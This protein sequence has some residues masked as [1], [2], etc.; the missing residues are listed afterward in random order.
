MLV[1]R[2]LHQ[3]GLRLKVIRI[4]ERDGNVGPSRCDP[5][6]HTGRGKM[7]LFGDM[8]SSESLEVLQV[9]REAQELGQLEKKVSLGL[10]LSSWR[11][12]REE[13]ESV[14]AERQKAQNSFS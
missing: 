3:P 6:W 8:A 7:E 5:K 14:R 4:S 10:G 2:T 11:K 1:H 9:L 12:G 13:G